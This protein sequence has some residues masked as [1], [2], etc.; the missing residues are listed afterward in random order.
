[1]PE[2][3]SCVC[4]IIEATAAKFGWTNELVCV[5]REI[6]EKAMLI[7]GYRYPTVVTLE[8][9]KLALSNTSL[10]MHKGQVWRGDPSAYDPNELTLA[11]IYTAPEYRGKGHA[12]IAMQQL[13]A[14]AD[15]LGV[16]ISLEPCPFG[17]KRLDKSLNYKQ[18]LKWYGKLGFVSHEAI[19]R[20]KPIQ[21]VAAA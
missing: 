17:R 5:N 10:L 9:V 11:G 14:V 18:L 16:Q 20:R 12:A 4:R 8:G 15:A 13:C 3:Q 1:M 21:Q 2:V 19:M 6:N 7:G